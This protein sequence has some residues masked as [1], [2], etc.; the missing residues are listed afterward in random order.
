M[1][2]AVINPNTISWRKTNGP[3]GGKIID[4]AFDTGNENVFYTAVYPISSGFLLFFFL[5]T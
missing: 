1:S 2:Q 3:G 4:I 5:T